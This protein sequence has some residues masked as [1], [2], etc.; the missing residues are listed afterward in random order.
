MAI[1][2]GETGGAKKSKARAENAAVTCAKGNASVDRVLCIPSS[3]SKRVA[4]SR[5]TA[6]RGRELHPL[7]RDQSGLDGADREPASHMV[8]KH[9]STWMRR[10]S[11]RPQT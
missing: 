4:N 1:E 8:T 10:I 5:A 9:T 2:S 11:G 7:S 6:A 3:G